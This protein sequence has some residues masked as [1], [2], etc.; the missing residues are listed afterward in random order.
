MT[1]IIADTTC[2]LPH[3]L[4]DQRGIPTIPQIVMFGE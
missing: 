3:D 4:L 2:G 1:L